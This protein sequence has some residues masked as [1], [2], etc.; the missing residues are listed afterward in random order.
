MDATQPVNL[1]PGCSF[2]PRCPLFVPGLCDVQ[3]PK[4]T[5]I[6]IETAGD[7]IGEEPCTTVQIA[8]HVVAAQQGR[9]VE[10]PMNREELERLYGGPRADAG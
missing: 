3:V 2:H 9:A 10:M 8:C 6:T 1:P 5:E 4:L 7:G